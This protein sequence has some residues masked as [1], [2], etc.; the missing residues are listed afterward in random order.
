[1]F[2]RSDFFNHISDIPQAVGTLVITDQRLRKCADS[3]R[4]ID[5]RLGSGRIHID[6]GQ[7]KELKEYELK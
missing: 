1:M 3:Y 2:I 6:R 4:P 7:F 5:L